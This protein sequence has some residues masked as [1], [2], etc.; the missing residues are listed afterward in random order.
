MLT[1]SSHKEV[2]AL[3]RGLNILVMLN[4]FGSS[5]PTEISART[6]LNRTTVYRLLETLMNL[7]FVSRWSAP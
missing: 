3:S 1:D 7:G 5:T 6:R 2:R 4:R